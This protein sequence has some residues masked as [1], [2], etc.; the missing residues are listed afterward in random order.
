MAGDHKDKAQASVARFNEY[1]ALVTLDW[2][3]GIKFKKHPIRKSS[4]P[5]PC[6]L[7]ATCP[8]LEIGG[9]NDRTALKTTSMAA[10]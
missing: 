4:C 5:F 3:C 8:K 10:E 7:I 9:R 1:G 6:V 2:F